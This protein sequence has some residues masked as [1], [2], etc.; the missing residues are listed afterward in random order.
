MTYLND[1][2][3]KGDLQ[4][5]RTLIET[6]G[7]SPSYTG[8]HG[9]A[10]LPLVVAAQHGQRKVMEYLI[11]K[12]ADVNGRAYFGS[13]PME[14][15]LKLGHT[16]AVTCLL[17]H[18]ANIPEGIYRTDLANQYLLK[19]AASNDLWSIEKL[20]LHTEADINTHDN[21]MKRTPIQNA[22]L[23]DAFDATVLLINKGAKIN[24]VDIHGWTAL[25]YAASNSDSQFAALLIEKGAKVNALDNNHRT[26]LFTAALS[27][28]ED[29]IYLLAK[30]GA[31]INHIDKDGITALDLTI[32][33]DDAAMLTCLVLNGAKITASIG[34]ETPLE[35]AAE[36]GKLQ[37]LEALIQL[38][39]SLH[40]KNS[41]GKTALELAFKA[42]HYDAV[43]M[44]VMYGA[45]VPKHIEE[46]LALMKPLDT[47]EV[48]PGD[49]LILPEDFTKPGIKLDSEEI[50]M[51][52]KGETI[53]ELIYIQPLGPD[54]P[55]VVHPEHM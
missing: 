27:G 12:G 49:N 9:F 40:H 38:G 16:Q 34:Q 29:L 1:F 17:E 36:N 33:N 14:T 24:S 2:I 8:W 22:V 28:E 30:N 44:L 42:G 48:L 5:V 52:P 18:N 3:S 10:E 50:N 26:P 51:Y 39:S 7:Y 54:M 11:Q 41:E 55:A 35:F 4:A 13:T 25:H 19:A 43:N 15:A 47:H 32:L 45:E 6:K 31:K 23:H 21:F 53:A 20:M 37:A 46:K